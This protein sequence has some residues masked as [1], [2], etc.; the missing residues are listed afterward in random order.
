MECQYITAGNLEDS[1][2][3]FIFLL[4][5]ANRQRIKVWGRAEVV[6]GDP[7][8]LKKRSNPEYGYE[9]TRVIL[10]HVAAWDANCPQHITPR[11]TE[12]EVRAIVQRLKDRVAQL[13][14]ELKRKGR[15]EVV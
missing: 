9:P 1:D 11:F 10:F 6:E 8:L 12:E 14:T 7:G 2:K 5:F 13:E 4:D 15:G 3:A